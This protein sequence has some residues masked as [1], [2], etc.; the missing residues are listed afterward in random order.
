ME[1][2]ETLEAA[3]QALEERGKELREHGNY[4]TCKNMDAQQTQYLKALDCVDRWS[5]N[6]HLYNACKG[7]AG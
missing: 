4:K 2:W 1:D 6:M 5:D 3:K 7:R